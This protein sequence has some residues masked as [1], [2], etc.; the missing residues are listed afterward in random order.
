MPSFNLG[1]LDTLVQLQSNRT[2]TGAVGQVISTWAD[3]G[4]VWAKV[5][6][7]ADEVISEGNYGVDQTIQLTVYKN[8]RLST[9]WRVVVQ[10][11]PYEIR[12]I[13][14]GQRTDLTCVLRLTALD[15]R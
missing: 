10:G 4:S 13:D 6:R 8:P 14:M 12:S 11:R 15:E 9:R 2:T 1:E 3:E 5:E 7:T